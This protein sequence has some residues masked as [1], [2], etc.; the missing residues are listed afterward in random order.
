MIGIGL[1]QEYRIMDNKT[2]TILNPSISDAWSDQVRDGNSV[3]IKLTPK[4]NCIIHAL[5][6][7]CILICSNQYSTVWCAGRK[8]QFEFTGVLFWR[9]VNMGLIYQ[10]YQNQNYEYILTGL[11]QKAI[12]KR[13]D[14]SQLI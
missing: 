3:I 11:G 13:V 1:I 5:Q 10:G 7:G 12:T 2:I 14:L 4:Q 6:Q 8:G 9:L